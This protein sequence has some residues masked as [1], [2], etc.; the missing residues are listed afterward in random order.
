MSQNSFSQSS[1]VLNS[2]RNDDNSVTISYIKNVPGTYCVYLNF[3]TLENASAFQT[4]FTV[5][6]NNGVLVKL[7][8]LDANKGIGYSYKYKVVQGI[9]DPQIDTSFVYLLPFADN[10][11][12]ETWFLNNLREK[13]FNEE[14][15]ENWKAFQF[16][17]SGED[18][19]CAARKGTVIRVVKDY[20]VDTTKQYSYSSS[21]N[22]IVLE[23]KDGTY[24]SYTGFNKDKIF[25]ELGDEVLPNQSL[26]VLTPYDKRG[27]NQLR[28]LVYYRTE[29][30]EEEEADQKKS[31]YVYVDPYFQTKEGIEKLS[32]RNSYIA[33]VNEDLIIKE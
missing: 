25:V 21:R 9:P 30:H 1:V 20:T 19:V 27:I 6:Y 33:S 14:R 18:T 16:N 24:A 31:S 23:H 11:K 32:N 26:G 4:K 7:E 29:K 2:Q 15:P 8:P 13:Y 28:F 5:N 17:A 10:K 3:N 12:V 22:M